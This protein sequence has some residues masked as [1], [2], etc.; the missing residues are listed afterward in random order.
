MDEDA[1]QGRCEARNEEV[2]VL[3]VREEEAM[4]L[5]LTGRDSEAMDLVS[6]CNSSDDDDGESMMVRTTSEV[7]HSKC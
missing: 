4:G 6:D 2:V 5:A 7:F 3:V 1:R